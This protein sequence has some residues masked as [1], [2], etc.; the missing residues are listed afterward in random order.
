MVDYYRFS[1]TATGV[2]VN[3][4]GVMPAG[5]VFFTAILYTVGRLL[6][7][8]GSF[9]SLLLTCGLASA[10]SVIEAPFALLAYLGPA[11]QQIQGAL[12]I[13]VSSWVI[14]LHAVAL[15]KS[16]A[17]STARA[18]VAVLALLAIATLASLIAGV[19]AVIVMFQPL[20]TP[21]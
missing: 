3:T 16:M 19:V 12:S 7:G 13:G 11:G 8:R 10:V 21:T 17:L 18:A 4:L 5:L 14:V 15:H 20:T 1:S 2:L 9:A 6:G